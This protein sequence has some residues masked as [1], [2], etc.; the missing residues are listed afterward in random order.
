MPQKLLIRESTKVLT[1]GHR[2]SEE[3]NLFL[4]GEG[5]NRWQPPFEPHLHFGGNLVRALWHTFED[6]FFVLQ[7]LRW[8]FGEF[9][10]QSRLWFTKDRSGFDPTETRRD[11]ICFALKEADVFVI[12]LQSSELWVDRVTN[13]P[14]W[15]TIL[16]E[17]Q[18]RDRYVFVRATVAETVSSL[19]DLDQLIDRHLPDKEFILALSPVA[20]EMTFR[21]ESAITASHASKCILKAALDQFLSD[22]SIRSKGRYH[23]FPSYEIVRYVFD[24]PFLPECPE[25][26]PEVALAVVNA[27]RE[28]YT[29]LPPSGNVIVESDSFQALRNHARE[30]EKQLA[31]KEKVIRDLD[32]VAGERLRGQQSLISAVEELERTAADRLKLIERLTW[33]IGERDTQF[34]DLQRNAADSVKLIERL[35][36]DARERDARFAETR[37]VRRNARELNFGPS[38]TAADLIGP[39]GGPEI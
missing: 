26:R 24:H 11:K 2:F 32:L 13:E 37:E 1:L 29:D 15:K 4:C 34:A 14:S 21:D 22:R 39:E 17:P 9:T 5:Y 20:L 35:T 23:Y 31:E 12:T 6:V 36:R 38:P 16:E 27:F 10:P 7:H 19:F 33:E 3:L 28:M 25:L 18:D 30:M 8:A